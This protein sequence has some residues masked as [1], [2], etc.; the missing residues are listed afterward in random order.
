MNSKELK[1]KI[2]MLD[3]LLDN[4]NITDIEY[5]SIENKIKALYTELAEIEKIE[6]IQNIKKAKLNNWQKNFL[7]SF[8]IG[9]RK[10]S[11]KQAQIFYDIGQG[12]PFSD[13]ARIYTC[14]GANYKVG[15]STVVI[16]KF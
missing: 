12:K 3:I 14:N 16:T 6:K 4:E 11:N 7:K 13:G 8:D 5:D 10:I 1:E 2:K 15:F 9:T